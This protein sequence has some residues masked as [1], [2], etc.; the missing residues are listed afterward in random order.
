MWDSPIP[1]T[2]S[3]QL[4]T[5][6]ESRPRARVRPS[7]VTAAVSLPSPE[8]PAAFLPADQAPGNRDHYESNV[9]AGS[10][11]TCSAPLLASGTITARLLK[12][13]PFFL[14]GQARSPAS[15]SACWPGDLER[16]GIPSVKWGKP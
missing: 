4:Q 14:Q 2:P 9:K 3:T 13:L 12:S 11:A 1:G 15:I 7:A 6:F 5:A 8:S 10:M 16:L